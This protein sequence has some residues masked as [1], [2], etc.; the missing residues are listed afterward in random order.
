[1]VWTEISFELIFY[2]SKS[3]TLKVFPRWHSKLCNV[4]QLNWF[5][6]ITY[7]KGRKSERARERTMCMYAY[8]EIMY[9]FES[10]RPINAFE[11]CWKKNVTWLF[12]FAWN[13]QKSTNHTIVAYRMNGSRSKSR[14]K[15]SL[16]LENCSFFD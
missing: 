10:A 9:A 13:D 3:V 12:R 6:N 15:Y 7:A 5:W 1:M 14:V 16:K 2:F 11:K 4:I 8:L